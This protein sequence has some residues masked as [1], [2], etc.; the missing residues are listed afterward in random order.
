MANEEIKL[1]NNNMEIDKVIQILAELWRYK[2]SNKYTDEEIRTAIEAAICY[3]A[4]IRS[5]GERRIQ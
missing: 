4:V 5:S 1:L 3:L 2:L